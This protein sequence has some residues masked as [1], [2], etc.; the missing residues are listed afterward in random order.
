MPGDD[1][2]AVERFEPQIESMEGAGFMFACLIHTMPFAQ[3]RA[4]SNMVER[5]NRAAW[6]MGEAVDSLCRVGC[7][8]IESA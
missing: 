4:V 3:V 1:S 2:V 6:K 5:R 7:A 8:I